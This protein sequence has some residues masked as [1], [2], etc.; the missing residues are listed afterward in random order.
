MCSIFIKAFDF[1]E[2][3]LIESVLEQV[4]YEL[5]QLCV[6]NGYHFIDNSSINNTVRM[7]HLYKNGLH[8]NNYGKDK[9]ANSFIDNIGIFLRENI[10]QMSD[11]W[12]ASV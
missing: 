1:I 6:K 5:L 4:N 7:V 8:L 3:E 12:I 9:L 10:F 11:F 2:H